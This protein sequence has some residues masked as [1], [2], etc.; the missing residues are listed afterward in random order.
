MRRV[1]LN[2]NPLLNEQRVEWESDGELLSHRKPTL[3]SPQLRFT[4][5]FEMG[6]GGT[7]ALWPSDINW[8]VFNKLER[9]TIKEIILL[10]VLKNT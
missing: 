6:S 8:Y 5:E 3:P 10:S 2:K 9:N 4:S 7:T 1:L